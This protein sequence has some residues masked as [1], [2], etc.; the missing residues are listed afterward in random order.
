MQTANLIEKVSIGYQSQ[1]NPYVLGIEIKQL[2][3]LEN[4]IQLERNIETSF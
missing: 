1:L 3:Y 4:R 2:L